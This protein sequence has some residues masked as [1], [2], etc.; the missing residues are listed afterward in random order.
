[1]VSTIAWTFEP[2]TRLLPVDC[3][4]L[5]TLDRRAQGATVD[6]GDAGLRTSSAAPHEQA[7]LDDGKR[8]DDPGARC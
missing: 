1:M 4:A 8:R 5:S 6:D 3:G 7:Q 2:R